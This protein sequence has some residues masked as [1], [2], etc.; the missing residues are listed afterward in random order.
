MSGVLNLGSQHLIPGSFVWTGNRFRAKANAFAR[1]QGAAEFEGEITIQHGVVSRMVVKGSGVWGYAYP[2]SSS[3]NISPGLPSAIMHLGSGFAC[4]S[5][6]L[7]TRMVLG[8]PSGAPRLFDPLGR[9]DPAIAIR[10]V[11]SNGVQVLDEN[12]NPLVTQLTVEELR[13]YAAAEKARK[14]RIRLA[15]FGTIL[16]LAMTLSLWLLWKRGAPHLS[17]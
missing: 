11:R 8:N 13:P 10:H 14:H 12:S 6:L 17:D 7:I 1:Q 3:T 15:V 9:I 4:K 5:K 16:I 2:P